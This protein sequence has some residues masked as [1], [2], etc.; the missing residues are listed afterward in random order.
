MYERES[1]ELL[2][3]ACLHSSVMANSL[4][5]M[6]R[7]KDRHDVIIMFFSTAE[8]FSVQLYRTQTEKSITV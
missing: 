8:D 1:V 3:S 6:P 2:F 7:W 5:Y 4:M